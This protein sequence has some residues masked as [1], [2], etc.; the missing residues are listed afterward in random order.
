M[1]RESEGPKTENEKRVEIET[2]GVLP[3]RTHPTRSLSYSNQTLRTPSRTN[4]RPTSPSKPSSLLLLR[5]GIP[6]ACGGGERG[7]GCWEGIGRERERELLEGRWVEIGVEVVE[8][9]GAEVGVEVG[10]VEVEREEEVEE[11]EVLLLLLEFHR[12]D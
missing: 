10:L 3:L 9:E 4:C 1:K 5:A 11:E 12:R 6:K 2:R 7:R 8:V